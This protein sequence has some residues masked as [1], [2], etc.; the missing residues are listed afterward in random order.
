MD[1]NWLN[2]AEKIQVNIWRGE[3]NFF[4]EQNKQNKT[5]K[6]KTRSNSKKNK[7]ANRKKFTW[8]SAEVNWEQKKSCW[9]WPEPINNNEQNERKKI[10]T[11]THMRGSKIEIEI[12]MRKLQKKLDLGNNL[13]DWNDKIEIISLKKFKII[14]RRSSDWSMFFTFFLF[15]TC[16]C[17]SKPWIGVCTQT[18]PND[19]W[20][21]FQTSSFLLLLRL[22]RCLLFLDEVCV[23]VCVCLFL[24]HNSSNLF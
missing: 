24:I 3:R 13:D 17:R 8:R 6:T 15:W 2:L 7:G 18:L 1:G 4:F 20:F 14:C 22:R 5:K 23:C 21:N 11:H 10:G 12:G 19:H 16:S 9:K